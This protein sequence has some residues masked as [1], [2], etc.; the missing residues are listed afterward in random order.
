VASK[1]YLPYDGSY[2]CCNFYGPVSTQL[3]YDTADY[4]IA[5]LAQATGD[6][7]DYTKFATLAQS[8]PVAFNAG[9]G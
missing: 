5:S 9:S 6:T 8:W 1:G 2:G 4:A 7:A 3:E